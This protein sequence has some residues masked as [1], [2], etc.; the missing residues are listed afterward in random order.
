MPIVGHF[1][2]DKSLKISRVHP[3]PQTHILFYSTGN[4][5]AI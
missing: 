3:P 5:L 4:G 2:F 1:E